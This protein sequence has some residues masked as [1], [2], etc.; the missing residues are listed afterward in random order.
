MILLLIMNYARIVV[1]KQI[2][3]VLNVREHI[4]VQNVSTRTGTMVCINIYAIF[5]INK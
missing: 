5:Y 4:V 2:I 1:K 3:V